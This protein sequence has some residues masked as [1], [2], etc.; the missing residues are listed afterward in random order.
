MRALRKEFNSF[1]FQKNLKDLLGLSCCNCESNKNVSYHHIVPLSV[2][3]TNRISNIAPL[4]EDCHNLIHGTQILNKKLQKIGIEKARQE[5]KFKGRKPISIPN[6]KKHYSRYINGEVNK[7]QL[8][9]E[10]GITRPTLDKLIK[11]SEEPK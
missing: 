5:G 6:F 9:I 4:C 7:V 8:A 10:L 3:G 11:E 2:G 1:L